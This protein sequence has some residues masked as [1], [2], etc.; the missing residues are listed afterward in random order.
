MHGDALIEGLGAAA[1]GVA[2]PEA[3]AHGAENI[4]IGADRLAHNQRFRIGDG[5]PDG[6]A[7]GRLAGAGVSG[8]V[9][10]DDQVPSE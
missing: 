7:A 8:T 10:Q 1:G 5:L 9:L 4:G 3:T 6:F 2:V